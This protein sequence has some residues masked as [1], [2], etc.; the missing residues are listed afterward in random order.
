MRKQEIS[1]DFLWKSFLHISKKG[2]V[3]VIYQFWRRMG[4]AQGHMTVS[5][6]PQD[7][8]LYWGKRLGIFYSECIPVTGKVHGSG[9]DNLSVL[10]LWVTPFPF[11]FSPLRF[12]SS[13][14][15]FTPCNSIPGHGFY[16]LA[17]ETLCAPK[18]AFIY[19]HCLIYHPSSTFL[20]VVF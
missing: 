14:K 10:M 7:A 13:W 19:V 2:V 16:S 12:P 9:E 11:L 1:K 18:V 3:N 17:T 20:S 5:C 15:S 4:D 6:M 8:S